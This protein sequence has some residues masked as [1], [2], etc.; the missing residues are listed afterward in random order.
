M[1]QTTN[2]HMKYLIEELKKHA[3]VNKIDLWKRVATDLEGSGRNRAEVNLS[4]LNRVTNPNEIIVV[5]GKVLGSGTLGHKVTVAAWNFSGGAR[6]G[7][8]AAKG[9][10]LSIIDLLKKDPKGKNIRIIG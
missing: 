2:V 6:R 10:C 4:R 3:S 9:E 1:T 7:I 8:E 5:P